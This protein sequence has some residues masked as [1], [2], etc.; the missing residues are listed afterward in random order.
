MLQSTGVVVVQPWNWAAGR[1]ASGEAFPDD[2]EVDSK[3]AQIWTEKE[4]QRK[5]EEKVEN[6]L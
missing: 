1:F 6:V 2:D 3:D 5:L 4:K